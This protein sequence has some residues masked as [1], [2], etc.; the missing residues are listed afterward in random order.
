MTEVDWPHPPGDTYIL[1]AVDIDTGLIKRIKIGR[2]R[3]TGDRQMKL[4]TAHYEQLIILFKYTGLKWEALE[5]SMHNSFAEHRIR[6]EWFAFPL[7]VT[8]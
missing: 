5:T 7:V 2:S 4:Q 1:G 3:K 8:D 6:G